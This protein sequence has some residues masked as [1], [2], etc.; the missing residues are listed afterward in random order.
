MLLNDNALSGLVDHYAIVVTA[1]VVDDIDV[2]GKLVG[3]YVTYLLH[4]SILLNVL[5]YNKTTR[6]PR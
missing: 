2:R 5:F 1:I 3:L 4:C 6:P